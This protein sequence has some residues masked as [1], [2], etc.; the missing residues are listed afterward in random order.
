M[1]KI[2]NSID[3]SPGLLILG[4]PSSFP[5][6]KLVKNPPSSDLA[7]TLFF[8]GLGAG[9]ATFAAASSAHATIYYSGPISFSGNAVSFDLESTASPVQN[10]AMGTDFTLTNSTK[11]SATN[12][13]STTGT[14]SGVASENRDNGS[15]G[16]TTYALKLASGATIGSNRT[17]V[18]GSPYFNSFNIAARDGVGTD[19]AKGDWF[20]GDRGFVGLTIVLDGTGEAGPGAAGTVVFGWADVTI[21]NFDGTGIGRYT[22]NGYAYEANGSAIPAGAIPEPSTIALLIAGAAGVEVMRR[23]KKK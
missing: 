11:S 6:E 9:A 18:S 15:G 17:F 4:P 7:Q 3:S 12:K 16:Q 22:L 21:N 19:A 8:S 14:G 5:P 13:I 20:P 23:R 10:P 1:L 2:G